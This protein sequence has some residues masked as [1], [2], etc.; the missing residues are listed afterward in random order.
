MAA[1]IITQAD[2]IPRSSKALLLQDAP[3]AAAADARASAEAAA[4]PSTKQS[5]DL[6]L[7][8]VQDATHMLFQEGLFTQDVLQSAIQRV[9]EVVAA[10][11]A[12]PA[13]AGRSFSTP[14][15]P[16]LLMRC[17]LLAAQRYKDLHGFLI[18]QFTGLLVRTPMPALFEALDP[19]L[20][21][22]ATDATKDEAAPMWDG[23]IKFIKLCQ[24]LSLVLITYLPKDYLHLLLVTAGA[25]RES[26]LR[27]KFKTWFNAWPQR[28]SPQAT[29]A[30]QVLEEVQ[31][32]AAA[33]AS[34]AAGGATTAG[35]VAS[36]RL[37]A[38]GGVTGSH[39]AD[40]ASA[41]AGM[42]R[43]AVHE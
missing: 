25:K 24:P 6:A 21:E 22:W 4:E 43:K 34:A 32:Q 23:F 30:R 35:A 26:G 36:A 40:A 18:G 2:H 38:G 10:A 8:M 19:Q 1:T 16:I 33:A 42:K 39:Q 20:S 9:V 28:L 41:V 27:D 29:H 7:A 37:G 5:G 14:M 13:S 15:T 11:G 17:M 3:S 31:Q 12:T